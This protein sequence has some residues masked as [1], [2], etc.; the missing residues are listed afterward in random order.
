MLEEISIRDFALFESLR[1]EFTPGFNVITGETGSGKS[2]LISAIT[3]LL[4]ARADA[5]IIR[6]GAEE[7]EVAGILDVSENS[8]ALAWLEDRTVDPDDGRI[9]VRRSLRPGGRSHIYIQDK[10]VSR[11]DLVAFT[12]LV[13]DVHGQHEHQS[14]MHAD[15]SRRSLDRFARIEDDAETYAGIFL[16][17]QEKRNL[18]RRASEDAKQNQS[19]FDLLRFR[20]DEIDRVRPR[21]GEEEELLAE[22][23]RLVQHEKLAASVEAAYE[24][25]SGSGEGAASGLRRAVTAMTTIAAIDPRMSELVARM[26]AA[27]FETDDIADTIRSYRDS[28]EYEPGR[29]EEI[30]SRLSAIRGLKKK[31]GMS[32]EGILD[33]VVRGRE[34]LAAGESG[35]ELLERLGKEISELGIK[36]EEAASALSA[37]RMVAAVDLGQRIQGILRTLGMPDAEF[38]V[39]VRRRFDQTGN[40]E[41]AQTGADDIEYRIL[42]N[43][44]SPWRPLARIASGGELSRVALAIKT[45][46][47]GYDGIPVLVF[48]E[49]DS[50]IGGE[51]GSSVGRHL[52]EL[53]TKHQVLCITHLATIAVCAG[54]HFSVEKEAGSGKTYARVRPVG[55]S[56][57]VREIARML[58]G[59]QYSDSSL[60]HAIAMLEVAG[61]RIGDRATG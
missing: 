2:L 37:A 25:L 33:Y 22:E 14:L 52:R 30:E 3:F 42:S 20:L 23:R 34:R 50:G 41:Y 39:D 31:L 61:T 26:E 4:G 27:Y 56:S 12:D 38:R 60:T 51:V 24:C 15:H 58:S 5:S 47:A 32:V 21:E 57:R 29:L 13:V 8:S 36:L 19:E 45:V 40:P 53:G 55:G 18:L 49:V 54:S 10:Q 43:P 59:D 44:G 46:L 48:D 7:C 11:N 6:S 16:R 35:E 28:L 9:L 1:V 17:L